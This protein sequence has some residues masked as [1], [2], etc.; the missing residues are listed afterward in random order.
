MHRG[1]SLRGARPAPAGPVGN[2]GTE[3][4]LT[5]LGVSGRRC[6]Q[7]PAPWGTLGW[8]APRGRAAECGRGR[9]RP[10]HGTQ[11]PRR[12]QT[13]CAEAGAG[14]G[15]PPRPSWENRGREGESPAGATWHR[16]LNLWRGP[17]TP[18]LW[19]VGALCT[20]SH[21]AGARSR[22]GQS[23]GIRAAA[24]GSGPAPASLTDEWNIPESL[25]Q[26]LSLRVS[27]GVPDRGRPLHPGFF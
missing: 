7:P 11:W 26:Q 14:R 15:G 18:S 24:R 8:R 16:G 6:A 9:G 23:L 13:R 22:T 21:K 2:L 10:I 1:G 19:P 3:P 27:R 20:R 25:G 12:R 5:S 4:L 17:A